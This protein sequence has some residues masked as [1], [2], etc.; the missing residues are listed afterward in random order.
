MPV[1]YRVH[2]TWPVFFILLA[3]LL[4]TRGAEGSDRTKSEQIPNVDFVIAAKR[5]DNGPAEKGI[6]IFALRCGLGSC[7]LDLLSLNEC[8]NTPVGQAFTPRKRSWATWA[9]N[10]EVTPFGSDRLEIKAF[11]GTHKVLPAVIKLTFIPGTR[12]AQKVTAFEAKG[13]LVFS[14][15]DGQGDRT[16]AD[17]VALPNPTQIFK[18][19][20][21]A[22]LPGLE[23]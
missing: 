5:V 4:T 23:K 17:L 19:D 14:N 2:S 16:L 15:K 22:L 20:C 9:G 6:Y 3:V 21:P 13:F 8:E 11:Q 10:L 12:C 7:S 1:I 18:M